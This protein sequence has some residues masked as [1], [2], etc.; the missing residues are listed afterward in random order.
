[1]TLT[2]NIIA[3]IDE[4]AAE[5]TI[6]LIDDLTESPLKD[7]PPPP[8]PSRTRKSHAQEREI[9]PF[10]NP[11]A[12]LHECEVIELPLPTSLISGQDPLSSEV[13]FKVH[14][15]HERQEKQLRNIEKERAAHEKVQLERLLDEL[16]GH[17]WLRVMGISGITATEK[18]LYEPKRDLIIKEVS[19]LLEKFRIWKEEEKRRKLE[20]DQAILEAQMLAAEN[21]TL[22]L[23]ESTSGT[24]IDAGDE[25]VDIQNGEANEG[26]GLIEGDSGVQVPSSDAQSYGEPPDIN[27]VDAW[28]ARQLLQEARSA[29]EPKNLRKHS[30]DIAQ[31]SPQQDTAPTPP[32]EEIP[33]TSFYSKQHLRD[34]AVARR[35]R[36]RFRMAFGHP[37]PDMEDREFSLPD[38]I[39]T[40]E[41]LTFIE[42]KRRRLNRENK[43]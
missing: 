18:K 43:G 7:F 1:L 32:A 29:S 34:A 30:F 39:L 19:A 41:I 4:L 23:S 9:S 37:V 13:Y 28:A 12:N 2:L 27:D 31:S 33:F 10:G 14:R 42:R 36:G 5:T 8:S 16:Q 17:D 15:R 35:R 22:G 6:T 21:G 38:D 26:L 25:V 24:S 3:C 11:L 20:R 40:P